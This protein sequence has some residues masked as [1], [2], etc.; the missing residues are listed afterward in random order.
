[1]NGDDGRKSPAPGRRR[2][3]RRAAARVAAVQALY[4][5]DMN[6]ANVED[7]ILEFL[8]HR[9]GDA[10]SGGR[11]DETLFSDV[12]RGATRRRREIDR[13]LSARLAA[14]WPLDRLETVLRAVLRCG[15]YELTMRPDVPARV[16]INE[17]LEVAKHFFSGGEPGM[18]NGV[19][20]RLAREVRQAEV[21]EALRGG[22]GPDR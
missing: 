19:L 6:D 10:E 16:V 17:Y 3:D 14:D 21:T 5:L 15:C 7:V 18:V 2:V 4:Q 11:V 9:V 22:A 20:D 1:M 12:V 13:L 8:A